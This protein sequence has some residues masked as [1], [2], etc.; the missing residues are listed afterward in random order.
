M[1]KEA[2]VGASFPPQKHKIKQ[3]QQLALFR[4]PPP[5]D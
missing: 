5:A 3:Q 2:C 4:F 1:S